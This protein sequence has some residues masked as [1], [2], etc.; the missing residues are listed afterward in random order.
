MS[1]LP[2]SDL[3]CVVNVSE[4]EE[5]RHKLARAKSNGEYIPLRL[6]RSGRSNSISVT[7]L[8]SGLWCEVQLEYKYLHPHM[9]ATVEWTKMAKRGKPVQ[10]KT[11][12][13]KHGANIHLKKG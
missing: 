10:L 11:P 8:Q 7:D 3:H 5:V 1:T 13:M 12:S 2:H 9:K 4:L 6:Y